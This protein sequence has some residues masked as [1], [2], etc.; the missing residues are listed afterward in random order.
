M[1]ENRRCR[2]C[3]T[4]FK[5]QKGFPNTH[6]CK[7]LCAWN[8]LIGQLNTI[9]ADKHP[10]I[11]AMPLKKAAAEIAERREQV[12]ALYEG[13]MRVSDIARK[14]NTDKSTISRDIKNMGLKEG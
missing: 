2:F 4:V 13:G 1:S 12:K 10:Y 3:G 5:P 7:E 6:F 14:L 8:Y 11:K 9:R